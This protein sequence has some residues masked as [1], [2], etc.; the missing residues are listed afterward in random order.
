MVQ[1]PQEMGHT[2]LS[3]PALMRN[4]GL[5]GMFVRFLATFAAGY[6]CVTVDHSLR[7]PSML[8]AQQPF[9]PTGTVMT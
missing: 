7:V 2:A 8:S 3:E 4:R 1:R 9:V 6:C 5:K